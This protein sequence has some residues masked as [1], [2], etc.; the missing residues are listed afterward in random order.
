LKFFLV[1]ALAETTIKDV[2]MRQ[3]FKRLHTGYCTLISNPFVHSHP[4]HDLFSA[5]TD[6]DP[7]E[8]AFI[9]Q[10]SD[11]FNQLINQLASATY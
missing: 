2:D 8:S 11:R 1:L 6:V 3:F 5:G 9:I 4:E 10:R 7:R